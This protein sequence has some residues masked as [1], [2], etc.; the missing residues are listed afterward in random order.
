MNMNEYLEQLKEE[1]MSGGDWRGKLK[2]FQLDEGCQEYLCNQMSHTQS[3]DK[4]AE[5]SDAKR[6]K[7][8]LSILHTTI[9]PM[10]IQPLDGFKPLQFICKRLKLIRGNLTGVMAAGGSGKSLF[11]QYLGLCVASGQKLF[12][13]FPVIS[14]KVLHIDLEQSERLTAVRLT[15]IAKGMGIDRIENLDRMCL[16]RIDVHSDLS[17]I[18]T[19]LVNIFQN[20]SLVQI[21]S[22][23]KLSNADENTAEIEPVVNMLRK[24]A[25]KSNSC[26]MMI[27]HMGKTKISAIQSGRGHSSIYDSLDQQIDL[28]HEATDITGEVELENVKNREGAVFYG[29]KFRFYDRGELNIAQDCTEELVF[30]CVESEVQQDKKIDA[31]V[32]ILQH[33]KDGEKNHSTLLGLVKGDRK[34]F[35]KNLEKCL[36]ANLIVEKSG[37]K[38]SRIF[39]LTDA[40]KNFIAWNDEGQNEKK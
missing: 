6:S 38:N 11:C 16:P 18:E 12:G 2:S 36:S 34:L 30:E 39:N 23:K 10:S 7:A 21:D 15:R 5:R 1:E 8:S 32:K 33:L 14:G 26:I 27:H 24:A 9:Q 22:L 35:D 13:E 31:K 17:K 3:F 28:N 19:E 40:G 25:E 29:L 20:Y 37:H 4:D